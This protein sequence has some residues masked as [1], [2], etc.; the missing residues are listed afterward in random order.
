MATARQKSGLRGVSEFRRFLRRLPLDMRKEI[1]E[2][3]MAGADDIEADMKALIPRDTGV[4]ASYIEKRLSADKLAVRVG[5]L[6]Q[7]DGKPNAGGYVARFIEYGT[8]GYEKETTLLRRGYRTE[9]A[10]DRKYGMVWEHVFYRDGRL[11]TS[12]TSTRIPPQPPRPFIA[13][14]LDLNEESIKANVREV[15]QRL[16]GSGPVAQ[17]FGYE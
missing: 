6:E 4:T 11:R 10:G 8:K 16:I 5:F 3:L 14:A 17:R 9:E 13:P 7:G 15:I 1:G 2:V 12:K